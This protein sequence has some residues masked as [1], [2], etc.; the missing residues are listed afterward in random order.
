M[1]SEIKINVP[2]F[3]ETV[4]NHPELYDK[5]HQQYKNNVRKGGIWREIATAF[6]MKDGNAAAAKWK[7]IRDQFRKKTPPTGTEA[8]DVIDNGGYIY[9]QYLSFLLPHLEDRPRFFYFFLLLTINLN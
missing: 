8:D 4:R 6:Q 2:E 3:I 1:S 5:A 7:S 9:A